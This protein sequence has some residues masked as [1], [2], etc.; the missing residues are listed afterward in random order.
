MKAM[1]RRWMVRAVAGAIAALVGWSCG[2]GYQ[3]DEFPDVKGT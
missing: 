1:P 3:E 2:G